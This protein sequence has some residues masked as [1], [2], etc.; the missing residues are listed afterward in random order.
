[1]K[2]RGSEPISE[3]EITCWEWCHAK[4]QSQAHKKSDGS[5]ALG[6]NLVCGVDADGRAVLKL[7]ELDSLHRRL[8]AKLDTNF[9]SG[10]NLKCM[11]YLR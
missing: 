5:V 1:V 9:R 3:Y 2:A 4:N 8:S 11:T 6:R 7:Y 10:G